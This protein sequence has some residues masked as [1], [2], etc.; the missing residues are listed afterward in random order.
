MTAA[1]QREVRAIKRGVKRAFQ[2]EGR[3]IL[4][5]II[6]EIIRIGKTFKQAGR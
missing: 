6:G 1:Q 3:A 5:G 4:K 2:R